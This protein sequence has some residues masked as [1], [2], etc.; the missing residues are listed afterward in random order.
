M[1]ENPVTIAYL[2][3]RFPKL[4]ETFVLYE[5]L[6]LHRL[7]FKVVVLPLRLE[8][9]AAAH[10]E[11]Q[12]LDCELCAAPL[13]S[14]R[15]LAINLKWLV[16]HPVRYFSTALRAAVGTVGSL[17]F[18]TGA[19]FYFPKAVVFADTV[20]RLGIKHVHAHFAS[21]PAMAAWIMYQLCGVSYSFTAHG[22]DLHVN[23]HMLR[24]KA[25]DAAF[26]ITI[27]DYNVRFIAERCGEETARHFEVL[28]CGADTAVFKPRKEHRETGVPLQILC[29]AAYREVKGHRIL[30]DACSL[31][32]NRGIG[33]HCQLIGYGP[34]ESAIA[35]QVE[36]LGLNEQVLVKGA[37]PRPAVVRSLGDAD[38][39]VL[40]SIQTRDGSREGIPVAL[41]E[42]MA[43]GLPV[44]ASRI[45]GIPELVEEG[46]SGLLFEP[47]NAV[48]M[49]DALE[50]LARDPELRARMGH[51]ARERVEESFDLVKNAHALAQRIKSQI[52]T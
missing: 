5:M 2:M 36:E 13:L 10:P 30:I 1:N 39:L 21:H 4:T 11:V 17:K 46:V 43:C 9:E 35:R 51:C 19:V 14:W 27:S 45:S 24:E 18:F 52:Q 38:V 22:T 3:S 47:G 12:A 8:K 49:A 7:H 15:T 6:E 31:L 44:V 23:Q 37:Q 34:Q 50:Q 26:A 42:G 32:R 25:R 40:S 33:F 48:E 41:M 29:I 20:Q 16:C 28:R